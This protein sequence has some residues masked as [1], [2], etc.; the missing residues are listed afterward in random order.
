MRIARDVIG[1]VLDWNNRYLSEKEAMKEITRSILIHKDVENGRNKVGEEKKDEITGE[2]EKGLDA[3]KV[4]EDEWAHLDDDDEDEEEKKQM[5]TD[6]KRIR[7][8]LKKSNFKIKIVAPLAIS[9]FFLMVLVGGINPY[10][11]ISNVVSDTS[12]G[13]KLIQLRET[14]TDDKAIKDEQFKEIVP[15]IK[16]NIHNNTKVLK[17]PDS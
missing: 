14:P 2:E 10:N 8:S 17:E 15:D 1:I 12:N 5:V 11:I 6:L 3:K 16:E 7:D 13:E 9:A 4:A